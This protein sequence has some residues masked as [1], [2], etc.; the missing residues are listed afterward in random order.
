MATEI[1][2]RITNK[3]S[4]IVDNDNIIAKNIETGIFNSCIREADNRGIL[5]KWENKHFKNLYL[6]KVMSIYSNLKQDSYIGN[7]ELLE[8]LENDEIKAYDIAFLSP[9]DLFPSRWKDLLDKKLKIDKCKYERRTEIATDIYKCGKCKERKCT[10]YQLQ[11]RSA[12]EPMTTFV[13]CIN[14]SN[15][16]KC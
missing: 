1:R 14:C 3:I 12:D 13:T 2:E 15:R 11:T 4:K 8:K 9:S 5:K 6:T 10:Y 7:N 16:W